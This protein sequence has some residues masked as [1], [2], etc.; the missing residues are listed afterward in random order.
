MPSKDLDECK[1]YS[2]IV[3]N[4]N[5]ERTRLNEMAMYLDDEEYTKKISVII[6]NLY[7]IANLFI[8]KKMN[9][10]IEYFVVFKE[11]YGYYSI[12]KVLPVIKKHRP[13][14]FKATK[15]VDYKTDL[16]EIHNGTDAQKASTQ[17]FFGLLDDKQWAIAK[18]NLGKYCNN[19]VRAMVAVEHFLRDIL[20]C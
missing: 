19:D 16:K 6:N 20:K 12:K 14:I 3:F 2:Y 8:L 13:D 7:D 1:E 18:E 10:P 4:Q 5:F 15:C 11:L 9:S 17:R